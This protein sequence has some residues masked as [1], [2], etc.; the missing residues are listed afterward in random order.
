MIAIAPEIQKQWSVIAP[1]LTIRSE[2]DYDQAVERLSS[3]IDEV[4]TNE[5]HPL[6]TLLDTLGI[7]IEAYEET[8]HSIPDSDS[9]DILTYLMEEHTLCESD[10]SEIGTEE[11]VIEVLTRKKKLELDQIRALANRFGVSPSVFI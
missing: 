7:L 1:I 10:L 9:V 2:Q 5:G 6:Y 8:H 3:L 4:G 11:T